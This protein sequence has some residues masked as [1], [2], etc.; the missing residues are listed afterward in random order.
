MTPQLAPA[1]FHNAVVEGVQRLHVL[2][3]P[4]TPAA[5]TVTLT[6]QVWI[7]TLWRMPRFWDEARDLPRLQEAFRTTA[8]RAE[9][10]P[11]PRNVMDNLPRA[12]D[13]PQ[14]PAPK[15]DPE[16][17][18]AYQAHARELLTKWKAKP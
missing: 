17:L 1:W 12:P 13:V 11:A 7:D 15:V 8:Q 4:G 6:A 14:L 5:E 9:R 3:L 16:K 2:S 18:R 10:W